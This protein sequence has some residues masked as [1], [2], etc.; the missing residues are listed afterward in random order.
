MSD[1]LRTKNMNN[2]ARKYN[3]WHPETRSLIKAFLAAGLTITATDNGG[4]R[5]EFKDVE[6]TVKHL[7]ACDD[8]YVYLQTADGKKLWVS[9]V[10]GN[11]PGELP[12][13]YSIHP[14]LDQVTKAHYD[15]WESRK[16][17]TLTEAE[18][19]KRMGLPQP[20]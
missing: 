6:Q 9:L 15:K 3:D 4:D 1:Q 13:D 19:L 5:E 18:Y 12:C 20:A 17:P 14:I 7:T 2:E 16:Q 8:S 11:S 10:Y